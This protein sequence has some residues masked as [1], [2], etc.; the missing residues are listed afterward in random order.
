[1]AI[2]IDWG[3]RVINVPRADLP[4]QQASPEVRTLDL[5][6]FRLQ[7][8]ELEDD[9][10]GMTFPDTHIHNTEVQIGGITLSRVIEVTNGYTVT[11]EDGQ[12]SVDCTGANSN[13]MDVA[14]P[15]QVSIRSNNSAG[16]IH[17]TAFDDI[18]IASAVWDADITSHS[19][20]GSF[21]E[22]VQSYGPILQRI[23]GL[24]QENFYIDQTQFTSYE[25]TD[26]MTQ[27]RMRIYDSDTNVGTD[28]GVLAT[29]QMVSTYLNGKMQTYSVTKQ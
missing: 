23:L 28:S 12:Y 29:Y 2:T 19:G 9:E 24:D 13:I 27:C 26:L 10:E 17:P 15:N 16:L 5:D 7:L 1:M 8:K 6:W 25:G 21:G 18:A 3:T 11:F 4:V 14:N 20:S 22:L